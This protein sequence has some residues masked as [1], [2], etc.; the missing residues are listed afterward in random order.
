MAGSEVMRKYSLYQTWVMLI[1]LISVPI[2]NG[3]DFGVHIS[4]SLGIS[5][6][7]L[8]IKEDPDRSSTYF[9]F[10]QNQEGSARWFVRMF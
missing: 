5:W 2:Q 4:R 8:N 1:Q 9:Q 7:H 3:R 10:H 6:P